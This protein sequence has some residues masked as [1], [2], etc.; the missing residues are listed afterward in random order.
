M[1]KRPFDLDLEKA[2]PNESTRLFELGVDDEFDR[3]HALSVDSSLGV[4]K[5]E[6]GDAHG[7]PAGGAARP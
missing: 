5:E 7:A 4:E 6:D 3:W 1:G 2:A